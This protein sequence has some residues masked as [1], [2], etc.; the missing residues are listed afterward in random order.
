MSKHHLLP[1]TVMHMSNEGKSAEE[2]EDTKTTR[3]E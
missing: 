1:E 2:S 3:E